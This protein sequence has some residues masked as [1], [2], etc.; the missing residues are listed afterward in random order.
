MASKRVPRATLRDVAAAAGVS[1]MTVSNVMNGRNEYVSE[2]TRLIVEREIKRLNYRAAPA[3]R[4]LRTGQAGI[5]GVIMGGALVDLYGSRNIDMVLHGFLRAVGD[6]GYQVVLLQATKGA[7]EESIRDFKV[8][9]DAYC[10]L[11]AAHNNSRVTVSQLETLHQPIIEIG[12]K[13]RLGLA[14]SCQVSDLS[15]MGGDS[16]GRFLIEREA[17]PVIILSSSSTEQY[18]AERLEGLRSRLQ[19]EGVAHRL[20]NIDSMPSR[21]AILEACSEI[22]DTSPGGT[23]VTMNEDD[24]MVALLALA[25]RGI[26]VPDHLKVAT[27]NLGHGRSARDADGKATSDSIVTGL[28]SDFHRLG[29][30]AGGL[31]IG[32]LKSGA[33]NYQTVSVP[34]SLHRGQTT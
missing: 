16:L 15:D 4:V 19:G 25:R 32:R 23:I 20:L 10:F 28:W 31:L 34:C 3:A 1:A 8:D 30:V 9:P 7:P 5:V 13:E 14:E 22:A 2:R 12:S 6:A 11:Y 33:F 17:G 26:A 21:A 18:V 29:R 24:A 27:L